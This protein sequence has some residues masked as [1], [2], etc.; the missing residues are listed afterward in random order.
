[1]KI[2]GIK[3]V[4]VEKKA[5]N[6]YGLCNLPYVINEDNIRRTILKLETSDG[7]TGFSVVPGF[8]GKF[9]VNA[10]KPIFINQ[11]PFCVKK[12]WED[13][14]SNEL[15]W[16]GEYTI[17]RNL[18]RPG[19]WETGW[20]DTFPAG[21]IAAV[22]IALYDLIGKVINLPIYRILGAYRSRVPAYAD[23]QPWIIS[24]H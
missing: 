23:G 6:A 16:N 1:M 21:S 11:D 4:E 15:V 14:Y 22:D 8:H 5:K 12:L 20:L 13:M 2:S 7:I 10:L 19:E 9:I 17:V 3:C 24:T 18:L